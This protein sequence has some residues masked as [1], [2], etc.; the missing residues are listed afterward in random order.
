MSDFSQH[1]HTSVICIKFYWIIFYTLYPI[2]NDFFVSIIL[3]S[4]QR[5]CTALYA[6]TYCHVDNVAQEVC[7]HTL[8]QANMFS[9]LPPSIH[10]HMTLTIFL[11]NLV[12]KFL[13]LPYIQ[14]THT[15]VN[16]V[17]F[18]QKYPNL[19]IPISPII[20]FLIMLIYFIGLL[21]GTTHA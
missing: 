20:I 8:V 10:I 15:N 3:G 1:T 21:H 17:H 6:G 19:W 13:Q 9:F 11:D 7:V 14:Y 2:F 5:F 16:R 4:A 12:L 18:Y